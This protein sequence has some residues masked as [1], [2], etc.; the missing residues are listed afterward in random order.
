MHYLTF[1]P[2]W[3]LSVRKGLLTWHNESLSFNPFWDLSCRCL[4]DDSR[5][6]TFLSIPFGIYRIIIKAIFE[7]ENITFNPF[8]D[9]SSMM[10]S[11][12]S[13]FGLYTFNPFWDLSERIA[14][15]DVYAK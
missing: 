9:L 7:I 10:S 1:N 15:K 3:D 13:T 14:K 12:T 11:A 2:F 8:W 5:L 6:Y 4:R